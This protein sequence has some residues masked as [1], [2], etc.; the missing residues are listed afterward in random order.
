MRTK[1]EAVLTYDAIGRHG[2]ITFDADLNDTGEIDRV[3]EITEEA[4]VDMGTPTVVTVT[5]E[6]GDRLNPQE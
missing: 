3:V 2:F 6:P 5:I 1:A 4:W